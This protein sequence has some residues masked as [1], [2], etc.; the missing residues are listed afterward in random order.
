MPVLDGAPKTKPAAGPKRPKKKA[1]VVPIS[2]PAHPAHPHHYHG[3]ERQYFRGF[4]VFRQLASLD[5]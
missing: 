3:K 5:L 1:A 2:S 4:H